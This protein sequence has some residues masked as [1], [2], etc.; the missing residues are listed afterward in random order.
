MELALEAKI[1]DRIG[2]SE[3]V[4]VSELAKKT[5]IDEA[6][7]CRVMKFLATTHVFREGER[8]RRA[9]DRG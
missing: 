3:G 9:S 7:L 8:I 1:A 6:K 4:H 2:D 5:S